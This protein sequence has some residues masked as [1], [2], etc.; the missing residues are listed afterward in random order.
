MPSKAVGNEGK[1]LNTSFDSMPFLKEVNFLG[2]KVSVWAI[3]PAIN[4]NMTVSAEEGMEILELQEENRLAIGDPNP[5]VAMVAALV[6]LRKSLLF[7]LFFM[8]Q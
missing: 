3:P 6:F 8:V 7:R 1:V 4:N 5:I 2:S